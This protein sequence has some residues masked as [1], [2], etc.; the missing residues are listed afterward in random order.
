MKI[1]RNVRGWLKSFPSLPLNVFS[2][3]SY[4]T[5]SSFLLR[6]YSFVFWFRTGS[7]WRFIFCLETLK[8]SPQHK[9]KEVKSRKNFFSFHVSGN[10]RNLIELRSSKVTKNWEMFCGEV[11]SS[12][13]HVLPFFIGKVYRRENPTAGVGNRNDAV[14]EGENL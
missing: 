7:E 13:L 10:Y 5:L 3:E 1:P 6:L 11:F 14:N 2:P 4:F 12:V 9:T 8:F